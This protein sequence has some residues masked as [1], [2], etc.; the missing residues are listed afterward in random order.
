MS[1]HNAHTQCAPLCFV[2]FAA[3]FI[4]IYRQSCE[5]HTLIFEFY[6]KLFGFRV[7]PFGL[8]LFLFSLSICSNCICPTDPFIFNVNAE[9]WEVFHIAKVNAKNC[10]ICNCVES[11]FVLFCYLLI[12]KI[13]RQRIK[14][15]RFVRSF[16]FL[17]HI[18]RNEQIKR[19]N[20]VNWQ[21][22][23]IT[24]IHLCLI[25]IWKICHQA[26]AR[27]RNERLTGIDWSSN[28]C[29]INKVN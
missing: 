1:Q 13:K 24:L 8:A 3:S 12:Q 14:C 2:L 7:F 23:T 6:L 22:T 26:Y 29:K 11:V 9:A 5:N 27:V 15:N 25:Q 20:R 10:S 16:L 28:R 17:R 4:C 21:S 18:N 19:E